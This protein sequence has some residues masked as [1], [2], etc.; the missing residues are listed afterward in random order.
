MSGQNALDRIASLAEDVSASFGLTF[1][2]ARFSQQGKRRSL[3]VTIYRPGGGIGFEDCEKVSSRLEEVLEQQAPPVVEASLVLAVQ[4]PGL[5]RTLK[6]DREFQVFAGQAVEVKM[7]DNLDT[8]GYTFKGILESKDETQITIKN[9][10]PLADPSVKA[11]PAAK[12]QPISP[13]NLPPAVTLALNRVI[14][15]RL[16]AEELH[17]K[18]R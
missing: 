14:A 18:L 17:G 5:G 8:L 11:R 2:D 13:E 12:R 6:T 15:V 9:P 7:K 10:S 3:E 4:S 16:Y 1:V